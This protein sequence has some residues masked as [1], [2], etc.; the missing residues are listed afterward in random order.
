MSILNFIIASVIGYFLGSIPWALVIGKVFFNKDIRE[1]GSGNLGGSNAGRVLG[2]KVG[3]TVIILD[4]LKSFVIVLIAAVF[5][6]DNIAAM[7]A[8]VFACIG[9]CFPIF[10][11]FKGGKGVATI[12]GYQ[13]AMVLFVSGHFLLLFVAPALIFLTVLAI[14]KWVSLSSMLWLL[15]IVILNYIVFGL[16]TIT[17]VYIILWIFVVYRHK[18]NISRII[19]NEE[20]K[21]T[22]IK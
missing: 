22:W 21:I 15:S 2:K 14:T 20:K 4:A 12:L 18:A 13:L 3:L 19:K 11:K 5:L 10:A 6:K 16:E 8:G 9:H 7:G 1:H 17:I